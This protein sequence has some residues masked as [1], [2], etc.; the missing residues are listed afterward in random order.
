M[1]KILVVFSLCFLALTNF[2]CQA[3]SAT[4]SGPATTHKIMGQS[5]TYPA[6]GEPWRE[7][8]KTIGAENAELGVPADTVV[9]LT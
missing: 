8:V 1:K 2:G 7:N 5:I 3:N 4:T 6:P 9:A